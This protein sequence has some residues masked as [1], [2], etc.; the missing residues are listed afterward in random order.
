MR[1]VGL[2]GYLLGRGNSDPAGI[3]PSTLKFNN[4]VRDI[5]LDIVFRE[6]AD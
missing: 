2:A 4:F 1:D 3:L 5:D 6:I